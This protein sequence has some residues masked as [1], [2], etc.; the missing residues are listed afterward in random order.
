MKTWKIVISGQPWKY[1]LMSTKEFS[2]KHDDIS[3][4]CGACV[5]PD[6]REIDFDVAEISLGVVRHE[7][8]HAFT[9]E[10]HLESASITGDQMEEIQCSLDE[11]LWDK[12][13]KASRLIFRNLKAHSK[14]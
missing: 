6:K 2:K 14:K 13:D 5:I 4:T 8:R 12:M 11:N 1:R 7:V 3:E 10:L 9:N